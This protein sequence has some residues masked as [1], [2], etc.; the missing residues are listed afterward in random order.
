MQQLCGAGAGRLE[1]RPRM[2]PSKRA[3]TR[4][5]PTH[6][7]GI[8]S[9]LREVC[10]G[11]S[12][13]EVGRLTGTC[14]ET[15]RRYLRGISPPP[16]D[17]VRKVG[18]VFGCSGDWL[19]YGRDDAI[20]EHA[21]LHPSV[22]RAATKAYLATLEERLHE[23]AT[24]AAQLRAALDKH[25]APGEPQPLNPDV[26]RATRIPPRESDDPPANDPAITLQASVRVSQ[27]RVSESA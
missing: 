14:S 20:G 13:G 12:F 3:T 1:L 19:L 16:F 2:A 10:V 11:R 7:H 24:E 23:L 6:D 15:V 26:R 22:R 21:P 4:D 17:F 9:R 18:E 5:D 25:A 27:V 8:L